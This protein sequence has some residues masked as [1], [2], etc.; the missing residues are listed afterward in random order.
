MVQTCRRHCVLVLW[1]FFWFYLYELCTEARFNGT[2][3]L[4]HKVCQV[5]AFV[6]QGGSMVLG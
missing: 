4:E 3:M 1:S 6:A 2:L 5:L